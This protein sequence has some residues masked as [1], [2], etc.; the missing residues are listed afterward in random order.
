MEATAMKVPSG[1]EIRKR[2]SVELVRAPRQSAIAS[3][4]ENRSVF[5]RKGLLR[6]RVWLSPSVICYTNSVANYAPLFR[7]KFVARVQSKR[8]VQSAPSL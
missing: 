5:L 8:C 4:K 3:P 2:R 6:T 7:R 1:Q